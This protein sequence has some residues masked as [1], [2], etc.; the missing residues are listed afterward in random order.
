M[1]QKSNQSAAFQKLNDEIDFWRAEDRKVR[2]FL[3]DDDAVSDTPPLRKL[4]ELSKRSDTPILLAIIPKMADKSLA[5]LVQ[6]TPLVTPAAHGYAHI[7]HT[8]QGYKPCELDR[9][10]PLEVVIEEMKAA[11]AKLAGLVGEGISALLVPPWN[12][13]HEEIIPH[14]GDAGFAGISA[15]GWQRDPTPVPMVNVHMDIIHWSGGVTGRDREWIYLNLAEN[16]EAARKSGWKPVGILTHHL[17]HDDR[18]WDSLEAIFEIAKQ[19]EAKWIAADDL[20]A[21]RQ[22]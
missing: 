10:R 13:I 7:S 6:E 20:L 22:A 21:E 18:A 9:F 11:R 19:C 5:K 16:L 14:V 4:V 15:K 1:T 12:R 17:V 2:F 8:P 3:R